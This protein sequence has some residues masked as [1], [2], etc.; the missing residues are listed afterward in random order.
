MK[1]PVSQLGVVVDNLAKAATSSATDIP[2]LGEALRA[3]GP[4]ATAS[5]Q[6]IAQAMAFIRAASDV[7]IQGAAAGTAYRNVLLRLQKQD[8]PVAQAFKDLG[9]TI[10]TTSGKMKPM[11]QIVDELNAALASKTQVQRNATIASR[12]S[13]PLARVLVGFCMVERRRAEARQ[14]EGPS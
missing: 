1:I 3:V 5:G 8:K 10:E 11:A 4:V 6:S 9:L 13:Q 2:M 12:E 14:G 7:M